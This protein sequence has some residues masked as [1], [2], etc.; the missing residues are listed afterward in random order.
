MGQQTSSIST[1][2]TEHTQDD[3]VTWWCKFLARGIAVVAG[4]VAMCLGIFVCMTFHPECLIAGI[5][6]ILAGFFLVLF[7]APCCC[8]FLD[9][10][11]QVE[12]FSKRRPYWQKGL[13]YLL[14]AV[15]PMA[16]CLETSTLVGSGL[17]FASGTVYGLMALGKKADREEML[18]KARGEDIEMNAGL[19]ANEDITG[20]H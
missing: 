18:V 11:K 7:E 15:L 9:F 19:V 16:L 8:V 2:P 10:I 5:W 12:D 20:T 1:V 4:L 3:G 17:I 13:A 6:Q 14:M